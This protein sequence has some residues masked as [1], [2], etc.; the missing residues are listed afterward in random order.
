[1]LKASA[2]KKHSERQ[3]DKKTGIAGGLMRGL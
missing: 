2:G 3:N 1:M